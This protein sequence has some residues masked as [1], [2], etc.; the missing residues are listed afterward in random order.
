MDVLALELLLAPALVIAA[1]LVG[2]RFGAAVGGWLSALPLIAGPVLLVYALEEGLRFSADAA[3]GTLLGLV[4]LS[5]FIVVYAR[6]APHASWPVA[7][8][9]GWTV[10]FAMTAVLRQIDVPAGVAGLMAG[11]SFL[12]AARLTPRIAPPEDRPVGNARGVDLAARAIVTAALVVLLGETAS[13]LGPH[14]GGLLVAFPVLASVLS[15][16]TH[17]R[18]SGAAAAGLLRGMIAGLVGFGG[19]CLGVA[20]WLPDLG[21]AAGFAAAA[22]MSLTLHAATLP[23]AARRA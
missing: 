20:L 10:F 4:S 12:A 17:A 22:A 21:L 6:L 13:A 18:E 23:L 9:A 1:T 16:F 5:A 8:L 15:A 19:F 3:S 11:V 7:L 2:W 14:L